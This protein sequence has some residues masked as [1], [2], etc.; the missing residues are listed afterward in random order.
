MVDKI[1]LRAERSARLGCRDLRYH[2]ILL[3]GVSEEWVD[4]RE[5]G[6]EMVGEHGIPEHG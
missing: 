5:L 1:Q 6:A 2:H 4:W 3:L